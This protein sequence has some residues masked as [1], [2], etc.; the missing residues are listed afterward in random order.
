MG[1]VPVKKSKK[2]ARKARPAPTVRVQD[3][4]RPKQQRFIAEYLIDHNAR[5]AAIRAGYSPKTAGAIGS[6]NLT[7]PAIVE[8]I[9]AGMRQLIDQPMA[10]AERIVLEAGR[11]ALSDVRHLFD[12]A[13]N[14]RPV[15]ELG[16]DIAA[17][18][19]SVE[20]IER[21]TGKDRDEVEVTRKVRLWDKNAA[22]GF[23]GKHHKLLTDKIESSV[24]HNLP[25]VRSM[26][27][28]ALE[29]ELLAA[30]DAIRARQALDKR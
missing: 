10:E 30:A 7:K 25:P 12:E 29:A 22:L 8:A 24:T 1:V 26:S 13:G 9:I 19:A 27:T 21:R 6:E 28:E 18:V 17:A 20:V 11:L 16:D 14:L 3:G 4:L 15:N 2:L 5:Q 23:L